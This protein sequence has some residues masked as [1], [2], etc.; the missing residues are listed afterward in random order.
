ME[1]VTVIRNGSNRIE[2]IPFE[3][4]CKGDRFFVRGE[5]HTVGEDAHYSGDAS[6]QG[7]LLFDTDGEAWFPEDLC[8]Y[9]QSV[10]IDLALVPATIK[11]YN[12][13]FYPAM[14]KAK[15]AVRNLDHAIDKLSNPAAARAQLEI[16]GWSEE[17][18]QT[19]LTALDFYQEAI[20]SQ[21][22]ENKN[23]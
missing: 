4:L 8:E 22:I 17:T 6:Y 14:T 18:V 2:E 16:I 10:V 23:K 12:Q 21:V 3:L 20:K 7:Y 11:E 9:D 5:L 13:A 1:K 15:L 19:I